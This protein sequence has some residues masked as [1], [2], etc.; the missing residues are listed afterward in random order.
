MGQVL[1]PDNIPNIVKASTTSI[2]LAATNAG[3]PVCVTVGGQQYVPS[4]TITLSTAA[5]GANGIDTG[6]IA[7]NSTYYVY[8]VVSAGN[9]ALVAS[10]AGISTGPT[11]FTSY[12]PIGIFTTLQGSTSI[13]FATGINPTE[14][15]IDSINANI[16]TQPITGVV[17]GNDY[18][19]LIIN[20]NFD[21]WQRGTSSVNPTGSVYLADKFRTWFSGAYAS[22]LTLSRDTSVPTFAQS[23]FNSQYSM[24]ISKPGSAIIPGVN[25]YLYL[26]YRVDG[27]EYQAIHNAQT[28][29]LQFWVKSTTTGTYSVALGNS[30]YARAMAINYTINAA[31]TWEKK[32]I[33]FVTDN[34]GTWLLDSGTGLDISFI[35]AAGSNRTISPGAWTT[36]GGPAV[37][38]GSSSQVNWGSTSA[39]TFNIAQVMLVPGS[40]SSNT[41]LVFKRSGK[42]FQGEQVL[43]DKPSFRVDKNAV[44]GSY[45]GAGVTQT[46]D[47]GLGSSFAFDNVGGFSANGYTIPSTGTWLF[48]TN[49]LVNMAAGSNSS[50]NIRNHNTGEIY[51]THYFMN[52]KGVA[53]DFSIYVSVLMYLTAGTKVGVGYSNSSAGTFTIHGLKHYTW[54][55]GTKISDS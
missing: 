12:K 19:N 46:V 48:S 3:K 16:F 36:T 55:Q 26:T 52:T 18:P 45:T 9:L 11:G 53:D 17:L 51:G 44:N 43:V 49:M 8:A 27:Y 31:N 1:R 14:P 32:T 4:A 42:M 39:T 21:Y 13:D 7:A 24:S 28:V 2:T 10:L 6:S 34:S 5:S 38:L 22:L 41:S 20:G 15:G 40:F 29:R 37:A 50:L 54:F 25:D 30:N 35:L 23:G 47:F 33:D